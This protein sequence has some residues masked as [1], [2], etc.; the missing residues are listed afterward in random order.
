MFVGLLTT[1]VTSYIVVSNPNMLYNIFA[2][3]LY[4][5][6]WIAEIIVVIFLSARIH[7]MNTITAIISFLLYAILN[8]LTFSSIFVVFELSSIIV[9]FLA[10]ALLFLIFA[11]IGYVTKIDLT[12]F[13]TYFFMALLGLLVLSLINVFFY[14][15]TLDLITCWIGL[16]IFIF[17]IA[18]DIQ[19]IKRMIG[20]FENQNN[21]A[22]IGAFELYLDFINLFIRLLSIFGKRND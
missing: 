6:I 5:F 16:V 12:K 19:K 14:N 3:K 7:K 18:Y 20:F 10:A 21:L 15:K 11:F 9:I 2:T 17:F 8:G 22:I 4:Y 1:F 13:G